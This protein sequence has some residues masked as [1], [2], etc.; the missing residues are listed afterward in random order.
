MKKNAILSAMLAALL[1]CIAAF[2]RPLSLA[3]TVSEASQMKVVLGELGVRNGEAYIDSTD[4]QTITAEQKA[5]ILDLLEKY[6][7]KR[8]LRTLFSDGSLSGLGDKALFL[9]VYADTSLVDSILI[10]SAG[11]I[12]VGD[13]C[14]S[15]ENA[16]QVIDRIIEIL[17]G[18]V[19]LAEANS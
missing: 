19:Q 3:D 5:A 2:F 13:T 11:K 7:Y 15:M 8:T 1:I 16:E 12:A 9:Y 18:N 10:S 4:Y 14:Y 6:P 17:V